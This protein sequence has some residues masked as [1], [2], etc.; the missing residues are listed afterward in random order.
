[1]QARFSMLP[2]VP[3]LGFP[4][5]VWQKHVVMF[6][7]DRGHRLYEAAK[8]K[9]DQAIRKQ[10]CQPGKKG[11]LRFNFSLGQKE[12]SDFDEK[13]RTSNSQTQRTKQNHGRSLLLFLL[14]QRLFGTE[15]A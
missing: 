15:E 4:H 7:P 1:M 13:M 10:R 8:E 9:T 11:L 5:Y 6:G 2:R 3:D 12:Q 14:K